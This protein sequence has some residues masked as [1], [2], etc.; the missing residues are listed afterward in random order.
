MEKEF[1]YLLAFEW[2]L[3]KHA[4]SLNQNSLLE[5]ATS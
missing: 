3:R 1:H 5:F 2:T 4:G